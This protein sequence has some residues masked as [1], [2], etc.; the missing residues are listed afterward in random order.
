MEFMKEEGPLSN[1]ETYCETVLVANKRP[2][3]IALLNLNQ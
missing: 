3:E 2:P 1:I